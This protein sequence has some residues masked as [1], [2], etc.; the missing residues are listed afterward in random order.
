MTYYH[1]EEEEGEL[2]FAKGMKWIAGLSALFA[3]SLLVDYFLPVVCVQAQVEKKIFFKENTRFGG[4]NYDLRI[5]TDKIKFKAKPD[6][7]GAVKELDFVSVC[8]T[9]IY[10]AVKS[11]SGTNS[12]DR[13][14]YVFEAVLPIFRGYGAFPLSLLLVATF[15]LFFKKDD[16]IAYGSGIIT[17]VL[18]LTMLMII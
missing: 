14:P 12:K 18:L 16:T 11:V 5:E 4:Q 13:L 8:H 2:P 17:I 7:F 10:R 15:C 6:L 3:L 9:P 1:P